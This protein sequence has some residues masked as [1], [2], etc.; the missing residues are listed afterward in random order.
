MPYIKIE[1]RD[2]IDKY[3]SDLGSVIRSGGELNFSFCTIIDEY[4]SFHGLN[5]QNISDIIGALE[6]AKAE[7]QRRIV[8]PYEDQKLIENGD[9]F[10]YSIDLLHPE[11]DDLVGS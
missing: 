1:D 9:V 6:G 2:S 10:G 3:A 8:G 11:S 4:I 5:Y 7:F